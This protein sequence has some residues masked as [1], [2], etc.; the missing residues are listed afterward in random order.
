MSKTVEPSTR[1]GLSWP[2]GYGYPK[3]TR[4]Y[5]FVRWGFD[6]KTLLHHDLLVSKDT[7]KILKVAVLSFHICDNPSQLKEEHA[8]F[9]TLSTSLRA[10]Y[11]SH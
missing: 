3:G 11:R 1:Q 10:W 7:L 2:L 6:W 9:C 8:S 4:L 5:C